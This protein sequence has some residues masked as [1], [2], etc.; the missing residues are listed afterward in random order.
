MLLCRYG[1]AILDIKWHRT[2]NSENPKLISTD[3]HVVRIWDPET[4]SASYFS[5]PYIL[6]IWHK[7][8]TV[9]TVA[10]VYLAWISYY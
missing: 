5:F 7:S 9:K 1:S 2:L 10:V 3:N 8:F 4:V 6:C